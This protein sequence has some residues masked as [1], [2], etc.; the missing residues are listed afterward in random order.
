MYRNLFHSLL[1][2]IT[3][4]AVTLSCSKT[5]DNE[6]KPLPEWEDKSADSATLAITVETQEGFYMV[7]SYVDLALSNDSMVNGI[8]VRRSP[9][10]AS[11]RVTFRKLYPRNY[12][13]NCIAYYNGSTYFGNF[14][15]PLPPG[16]VKDTILFVH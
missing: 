1:L 6:T 8:L 9:T 4:A 2:L 14:H 15:T 3:L 11:G 12:F 13:V 5:V 16:S 7:G 10:N